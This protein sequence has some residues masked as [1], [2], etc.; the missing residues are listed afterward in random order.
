MT[1]KTSFL[2]QP[3]LLR[4]VHNFQAIFTLL[5]M[6]TAFWTYN[7]YD[8][9]WGK[10]N[11]LPDWNEIEGIHGTF[12]L[13][14]LLLLPIF[15]IYIIHRGQ[16]KLVQKNTYNQLKLFNKPIW[17]YSLHRIVNTVSIFSLLFAVFTGKMMDEKWLP[18]GN[19]D[20]TWYYLHLIS[21]LVMVFTIALHLLMNAK[22]GGYPLILSILKLQTKD[23]DNFITWKNYLVSIYPQ[24]DRQILQEWFNLPPH[25]KLLEI[26]ILVSIIMAWI[27]SFFK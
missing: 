19:L 25:F 15:T 17:W 1:K 26:T 9:R 6:I 22:V 12:G 13:F 27:I 11:I 23:N 10:I 20:H 4:I 5:A 8:G 14:S 21:L 18:A 16:A 2:Y 7:T 3:L 24:L